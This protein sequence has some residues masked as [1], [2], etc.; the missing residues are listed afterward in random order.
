M[1]QL[2]L[3]FQTGAK[4]ILY[5]F[6]AL[7]PLWFVPFSLPTEF[8]REITFG[9]L[10]VIAVILRLL[11]ILRT[12]EVNFPHSFLLWAAAALLVI[13]SAS[14]FLSKSPLL[15][16]LFSEATGEKLSTLILGILIML[17][18]A[19]SFGHKREIGV[20]LFILLIAGTVSALITL[21]QFLGVPVYS[22]LRFLPLMQGQNF[23]VVGTVNGLALFYVSLLLINVGLILSGFFQTWKLWVRS[24]LIVSSVS[25]LAVVLSVNFSTV[26]IVLLGSAIFLFGL[27]FDRNRKGA[28]GW[29]YWAALGL[30]LFSVVMLLIRTQS[31]AWVQLPAEVNPS[32]TAT[33]SI[34]KA[35]FKENVKNIFLGTGPATF[36]LDWVKYKDPS[37]NQTIFW[38]IRFNQGYSW[39]TTLIPTL[40]L[41][42]FFAFL[43]FLSVTIF[44]F[45][46]GLLSSPSGEMITARALFLGLASIVLTGFLYPATFTLVLLLFLLV[47]LLLALTAETD[48]QASFWKVKA[49]TIKFEGPWVVFT[50]SL[51]IIFSVSLAVGALYFAA[52]KARAAWALENGMAAF[53]KGNL[54]EAVNQ[55]EKSIA[56]DPNNPKLMQTLV[57]ARLEQ[58]RDVIQRA[59][60]GENVQSEF[61]G[62]VATAIQNSQL[63][64]SIYPQEPIFWRAQGSLYEIIIPFIAGSERFAVE[65]YQKAAELDPQNPVIWTDL[66][67]AYLTFAER[68]QFLLNQNQG[69]KEQLAQAKQFA[70]AEAEK[71]FRKATEVKPDFAQAHFLLAQ[72]AVR[73]NKLDEAIK[74]VEQAR[75][76]APVDIGIAFQLGLLY[77]QVNDFGRAEAEFLR[78]V[79]I[80][81]NYSNARYFLGLIY[82]RRGEREK[83]IKEFEK[84]LIF[85][86]ANDE[87][88]KVLANLRAKKRALE[89]I[90]P[91][92]P[93]KRTEPPVE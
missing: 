52:D 25:F 92:L 5:I 20:L 24:L 48:G 26:W 16:L 76:A 33:F 61:Q 17:L 77:Y 89:G 36:G 46:R 86:P 74:N 49:Y 87:V 75:Q 3:R 18:A 50:S 14:V 8:G 9:V 12:G 31:L 35:V 71:A 91:P 37:I 4:I 41:M 23:N 7:L 2:S 88:K 22:V 62:T 13:F 57:L 53:N 6:A 59:S 32:L 63:V 51:V 72:T 73:Q 19:T 68:V 34:S 15:S 84:I 93:E 83:A 56:L 11:I 1:D 60:R 82:D 47:G 39:I 79:S 65:S 81:D 43:G 70:L 38:G 69:Q 21:L 42:G 54:A 28:F 78:A 10:I 58:I 45:L 66:G 85:N 64:L 29:R 27:I 55:F 40:G 80:N 30:I 44:T 67:R 90:S